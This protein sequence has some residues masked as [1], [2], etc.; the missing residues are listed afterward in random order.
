MLPTWVPMYPPEAQPPRD[1]DGD[2]KELG[3]ALR[4][5]Q[6]WHSGF[7]PVTYIP[8]KNNLM[9]D[10]CI[11]VQGLKGLGL[12]LAGPSAFRPAARHSIMVVGVRSGEIWLVHG[13][14]E[15]ERSGE[16]KRRERRGREGKGGE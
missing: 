2:V 12:W 13:N 16:V 6:I 9:A 7:H 4:S 10:G 5:A 14:R 3:Q 1:D 11:M 8:K 15:R